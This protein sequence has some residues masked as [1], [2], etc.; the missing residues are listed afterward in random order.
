MTRARPSR[1]WGR[2]LRRAAV[3]IVAGIVALLLVERGLD[4]VLPF[5]LERLCE[6]PVSRQILAADGTVLRV[7]ATAV[8]ERV[9]ALP[10]ESMS[11]YV[12]DAVVTAEDE[13]FYGHG[14]VDTI[15]VGRAAIQNLV[16]ARIV[17]GAS[18]ITMQVVRIALA[19][20]SRSFGFKLVQIFRAR[21][22]E[23]QLSKQ[24][25]LEHYC[26]HVPLGGA[27]RGFEAA[28]R[29]WFGKPAADLLPAEAA[30]LVAMLP[31]PGYRS[32]RRR[33]DLVRRLR[34]RVLDRM[35]ERGRLTLSEHR[36][37]IG[38]PLGASRR[39]WPALAP[40]ACDHF[41]RTGR[42]AIVRT[43]LDVDL[44]RRLEAL[45]SRHD[46]GLADGL[47]MVVMRRSD[48]ALAA[49]I[50]SPDYRR[51]ALNT[52][53][54][55]RSLGSTLKPF[56]FAL[57][58]ECGAASAD[59]LLLDTK[60]RFSD[61][62]PANFSRDH[63]GAIGLAP[64]L[65]ASRNLPAVRL[66]HAVGVDRFGALLGQL[67]L[68]AGNHE[69]HL[70]AALGTLS[71]SPLEL[72]R[73]YCRF[74]GSPERGGLRAETVRRVE[75]ALAR[76]PIGAAAGCRSVAFKTGT[77]SGRRDAW[78]VGLTPGHVVV[79]W[80]GNLTGRGAAGLVGS[81]SALRLMTRVVG[82]L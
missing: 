73:A 48:H 53:T 78:C 32:P 62:R 38:S 58:L 35:F 56:L 44:Q 13:R 14:G 29:R 47:A 28:A 65:A 55:R 1:K 51:T 40:H 2:R 42:D 6:L 27:V 10:L 5:P 60:A 74:V 76:F 11:P 33:P 23:R 45:A 37:A 75:D 15:A 50:G 72:A 41:E 9:L 18:T 80:T 3:A 81:R 63:L 52:A 66:L 64:A 24:A 17:S 21:Q 8:D 68:P 54:C 70:D 61:Y 77:S 39:P 79:V 22:L 20:R 7:S 69:L 43:R 71:A 4:L 12:V 31:A 46:V 82:V 57:A 49:M 34:D 59:G 36:Q 26:N 16:H 30:T 67:G 19:E 25:I